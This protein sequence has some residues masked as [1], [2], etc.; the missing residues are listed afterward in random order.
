MFHS[1]PARKVRAYRPRLE[2]LEDRTLLSIYLVDRLTDTGAGSGLAGDL[3]YCITQAVNGDAIN[4]GVNGTINLT[5]ALPD[6]AHNVSIQGPGA[7]LLT[8]RGAGSEGYPFRVFTVPFGATVSISGLTIT[9]G[10]YVSGGGID[11][12]GTL[13]LSN[14]TVTGNEVSGDEVRGGG[15][16]NAGTLTLSNSTVT[17]NE[18]VGDFYFPYAPGGGIYNG[19]TSGTAVLTISNS[20]ISGNDA[21]SGGGIANG[22]VDTTTGQYEPG[23]TVTLSDST[24]V[25]IPS[26]KENRFGVMLNA[27][28]E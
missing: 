7:N 3:R 23:G 26:P 16:D 10:Y 9:N 17:G 27:S 25:D 22:Y 21:Y 11:N 2:V 14:S 5:G 1:R 28:V 18:A 12:G 4:F 15:I 13:T 24:I 19:N 6:L 20:T 8:V